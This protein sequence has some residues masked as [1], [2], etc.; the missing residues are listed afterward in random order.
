MNPT[1]DLALFL[2]G[3]V[4]DGPEWLQGLAIMAGIIL[5]LAAILALA[6]ALAFPCISYLDRRTH[7]R[8]YRRLR[9]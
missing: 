3:L 4:A 2:Q 9:R 8:L 5:A 1:R 6:T 7:Q